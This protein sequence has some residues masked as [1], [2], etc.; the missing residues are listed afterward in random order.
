MTTHD[1]KKFFFMA[2]LPR[3]GGTLLSSILNQNPDIYV[4]PQS[5]LPNTLGAAYNQYQSKENK[6]ANQFD[7]IYAVME[8]II[9][10]FY[11]VRPEK[12]IVDKNFSWLDG[13][14]YVI[15]ENHLK[16]DIRV[17]CPVRD[18]LGILAS[19]NRLCENDP[20][21]EY[22][23]TIYKKYR[24][25]SLMADKR[26][27]YFMELGDEENGIL[28]GIENL[29]RVLYP[30]F[31]DN[32]LLVDYDDLTKD[33]ESTI[34]KVYDFLEIPNYTHAYKSLSTPHKYEDTWGVKDHHKVKST[35]KREEYDYSKIFSPATIKQYS[36]LE[37][38]RNT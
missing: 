38:W 21:N 15:L 33:T 3:S 17:I 14:P 20:N 29:K 22:D 18:V 19:W 28:K 25:K 8:T 5:T 35:I 27:R 32:I 11:S 12:Y 6:D 2:G 9:P 4:S 7:H 16:N 24:D 31:K 13:H 36:G 10:T 26:A 37:F 1:E 34:G 23:K 30:E